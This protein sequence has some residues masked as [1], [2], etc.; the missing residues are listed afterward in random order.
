MKSIVRIVLVILSLGISYYLCFFIAEH[1]F[2]DKFFY[3]KSAD[4][5]YLVSKT[6]NLSDYGPRANDLIWLTAAMKD[7]NPGQKAAESGTY[8]IAVIGDSY[9]WGQG[10]KYS[11]RFVPLLE[12][13]LNKIR[14]TKVYSFGMEG[15]NLLENYEKMKFL[16]SDKSPVKI[17]LYILSVVYDDM[18]VNDENVY[19]M[20]Y[21]NVLAKEC[22]NL[23]KFN[24]N[25]GFGTPS[26][27]CLAQKILTDLPGNIIVFEPAYFVDDHSDI[28]N[29]YVKLFR[30]FNMNVINPLNFLGNLPKETNFISKMRVSKMEEHPSALANKI[31]VKTLFSAVTQLPSFK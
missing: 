5:G 8:N 30:S 9:V 22:E 26:N 17:D 4:Y 10:L 16:E 14:K 23:G 6:Q 25:G 7:E 15:D 20:N 21:G 11:D 28:H 24:V 31:F 12:K 1:F 29:R 2:F 13:E 19:T 18:Y 3:R 27:V